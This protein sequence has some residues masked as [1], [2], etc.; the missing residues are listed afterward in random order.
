MAQTI[1]AI[2]EHGK[3]RPLDTVDFAEGQE[4]R[5]MVVSDGETVTKRE[6]ETD[7]ERH[8]AEVRRAL[9]DL[10]VEIPVRSDPDFDEEALQREID[11][12]IK[13]DVQASQIIINERREGP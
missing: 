7:V 4:I 10:L 1:R 12:A 2:Y 3:L 8:R 5:L 13:G 11:S 9:G 6:H